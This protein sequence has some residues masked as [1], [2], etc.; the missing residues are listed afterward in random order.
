VAAS[1]RSAYDCEYLV[2]AETLDAPLVMNDGRVLAAFP[3]RA[4][5]PAGFARRRGGRGGVRRPSTGRRAAA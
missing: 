5:S 4:A 2:L 3:E 1:S